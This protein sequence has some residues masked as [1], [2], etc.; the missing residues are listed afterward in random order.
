MLHDEVVGELEENFA[1]YVGAKYA[2]TANS[3]SSLLFLSLI[4]YNEIIDIPSTMPIVVPNAIITAGNQVRFYND[5]NWVGHCY[6]LHDNIFDSAQEVRK[7][8]YHD[9]N[10]DNA[11]VIF[12][13][14][15]TKPVGGCDGG[16]VVSN[17]K[18]YIDYY[19]TMTMNGT[20]FAVNNWDRQHTVAGYKM[21]CNSLQA[22]IANE[23]LKKL[24]HKN[25]VLDE[26][27]TVYNQYLDYNNTSNHLYRIRV[28]KNK[29]FIGTMKKY[30]IQCGI[31]HEHCHNKP[32]F[33]NAEI[34][35]ACVCLSSSERESKSTVSLPFH[36]NL[37]QID[38]KRVIKYALAESE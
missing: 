8:Q 32:A 18:D 16:I 35:S 37:T 9:L 10:N 19:K 6:H 34:Q 13:F 25:D 31:H 36:E 3:A 27:R 1:Q 4:K 15:P 21:H 12:S 29:E 30:G 2:C 7:N 24:D 20:N 23:N 5:I 14:Y 33:A 28:K 26:I 38:I 11:V 17:N 22:F